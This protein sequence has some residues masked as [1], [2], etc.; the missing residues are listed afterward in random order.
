MKLLPIGTKV[1]AIGQGEYIHSVKAGDKGVVVQNDLADQTCPN[2]VEWSEDPTSTFWTVPHKKLKKAKGKK[3]KLKVG[4]KARVIDQT[5]GHSFEIGQVVTIES[6]ETGCYQASAEDGQ[7][8]AVND[9]EIQKIKLKGKPLKVGDR[10]TFVKSGHNV[11]K[12]WVPLGTEGEI[13][14]VDQEDPNQTYKVRLAGNSWWLGPENIKKVSLKG[15][16]KKGERAEIIGTTRE[17]NGTRIGH[18]PF[19]NGEIVSLDKWDSKY[20]AW[21]VEDDGP[22]WL[23]YPCD[24]RKLREL[25]EGE[26]LDDTP[27]RKEFEK[28][29]IGDKVICTEHAYPGGGHEEGTEL[30]VKEI[31]ST[32]LALFEESA[33]SMFIYKREP[34]FFKWVPE[35]ADKAELLEELKDL[36]VEGAIGAAHY[37]WCVDH[38]YRIKHPDL[39]ALQEEILDQMQSRVDELKAQLIK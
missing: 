38:G 4:D 34:R 15:G 17:A 29:D 35:T 3:M 23:V 8:W 25:E 6:L 36:T 21:R 11:T 1:V 9:E 19:G 37:E 31:T 2:Q 33:A 27:L 26:K 13:L 30:T 22:G 39:I 28:F 18:H 12:A 5:D 16:F 20:K 32:N 10:V 14:Q 7:S 24:L